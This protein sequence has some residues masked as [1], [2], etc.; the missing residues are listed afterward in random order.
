MLFEV[1][2]ALFS[3]A[4]KREQWSYPDVLESRWVTKF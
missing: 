3:L 1:A 2:T 4:V